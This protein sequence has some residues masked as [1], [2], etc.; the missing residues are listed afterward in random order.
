MYRINNDFDRRFENL[1]LY[2]SSVHGCLAGSKQ[3][4]RT[5][6]LRGSLSGRNHCVFLAYVR[7]EITVET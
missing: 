1:M 2:V 7:L 5:R 3:C 6:R 4:H